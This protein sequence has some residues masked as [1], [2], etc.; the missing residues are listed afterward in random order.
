ME[1]VE[2]LGIA[3]G[4]AVGCKVVDV[5]KVAG[6]DGALRIGQ[7]AFSCGANVPFSSGDDKGAVGIDQ[8]AL[9]AFEDG[10]QAFAGH[11]I[12]D[13]CACGFEECGGE[14]HEV[15]KVFNGASRGDVVGPARGE[16]DFAADVVEVAFAAGKA[17]YAVVAADDDEGV[18]EFADFFEALD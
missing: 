11:G 10:E 7:L 4:P 14:V 9:L 13:V 8:A 3:H 15:D 5:E 12:G 18:V 2:S 6:A 17:R 1:V 16:G